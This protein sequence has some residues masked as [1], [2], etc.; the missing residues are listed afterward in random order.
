ML[1]VGFCG[2]SFLKDPAYGSQGVKFAETDGV[3]ISSGS[4]TELSACIRT[5]D[6]KSLCA[7]ASLQLGLSLGCWS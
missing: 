5:T 7:V 2:L 1:F 4:D 3:K 6:A